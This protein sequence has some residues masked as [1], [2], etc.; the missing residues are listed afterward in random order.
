MITVTN[1]DA[2]QITSGT[3]DA[4]LITVTAASGAIS[5]DR[6]GLVLQ[7]GGATA[8]QVRWQSS[9]TD[10]GFIQTITNGGYPEMSL[11]SF[12]GFYGDRAVVELQAVRRQSKHSVDDLQVSMQSEQ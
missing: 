11:V 6:N 5:L 3:L 10:V 4:D 1:L 8:N 7:A 9:G 12:S 2:S